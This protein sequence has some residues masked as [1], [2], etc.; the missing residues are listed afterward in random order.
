[1][2]NNYLSNENYIYLLPTKNGRYFK[3]GKSSVSLKR[4]NKL[5]KH[6]NF[7]LNRG[8]IFTVDRKTVFSVESELINK[9]PKCKHAYGNVDGSTEIRDFR[10]F[11]KALTFLR[12]KEFPEYSIVDIFG[13]NI[14]NSVNYSKILTNGENKRIH[15]KIKTKKEISFFDYCFFYRFY[16]TRYYFDSHGCLNLK[17]I[18]GLDKH[19]KL[20]SDKNISCYTYG[21]G[22]ESRIVFRLLNNDE[23]QILPRLVCEVLCI[24]P[25]QSEKLAAFNRKKKSMKSLKEQCISDQ[26]ICFRDFINEE[27]VYINPSL[28]FNN[29]DYIRTSNIEDNFLLHYKNEAKKRIIYRDSVKYNQFTTKEER[30]QYFIRRFDKNTLLEHKFLILNDDD[31]EKLFWFCSIYFGILQKRKKPRNG[32]Y[33]YWDQANCFR[34]LFSKRKSSL[35]CSSIHSVLLELTQRIPG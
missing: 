30:D 19:Y 33:G 32:C 27:L 12:N 8:I 21:K 10:F 9:I 24:N 5:D 23:E 25:K 29:L 2:N 6:Y 16:F 28:L 13:N 11:G 26:P 15:K 35:I 7:Y 14:G 22:D 1:M 20:I 18:N 34:N 17:F 31:A 4:I 3:I